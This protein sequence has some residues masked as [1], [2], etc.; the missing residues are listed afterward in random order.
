MAIMDLE[1]IEIDGLLYPNIEVEGS[2][3]L[4]NLGKYGH[5]RLEYLHGFKQ[6]MYRELLFTG[7]LAEHC[8]AV[9][10][11]AFE[12]SERIRVD[13]LKQHPMPEEDALE[14]IRIS[15]QAQAV[16]DEIVKTELIYV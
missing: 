11:R 14:R 16:A 12:L 4:K 9:D 10:M 3:L 7:K 13:Y 15:E 2:E 1:Y 5:L 8:A 6:E